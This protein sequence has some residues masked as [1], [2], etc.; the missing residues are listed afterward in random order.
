M[1]RNISGWFLC[2]VLFLLAVFVGQSL[3]YAHFEGTKEAINKIF[4]TKDSNKTNACQALN[5]V[6]ARINP[7]LPG[8]GE[9]ISL[10]NKE[11]LDLLILDRHID[12]NGLL[13]EMAENPNASEDLRNRLV[14]LAQSHEAVQVETLLSMAKVAKPG[15]KTLEYCMDANIGRNYWNKNSLIEFVEIL[16]KNSSFPKEFVQRQISRLSLN[17]KVLASVLFSGDDFSINQ[18][19]L[20]S[21]VKKREISVD[22]MTDLAQRADLSDED[23]QIIFDYVKSEYLS[24]KPIL[25]ALA[26][27][28]SLPFSVV[29]QIRNFLHTGIKF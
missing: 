21:L 7:S 6:L 27:N 29:E 11:I 10:L 12:I 9:L 22:L 13:P 14:E 20:K 15:S 28:P 24:S 1:K 2:K 8:A 4:A 18:K 19:E 3:A 23:Y 16:V 25:N 17:D 26:Q 5:Y